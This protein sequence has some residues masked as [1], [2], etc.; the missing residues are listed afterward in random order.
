MV[1]QYNLCM[2]DRVL[3]CYIAYMKEYKGITP[4]DSPINGGLF[5]RETGNAHE[6][7]N[8]LPGA[9]GYVNGF[10]ETKH[11][12][13]YKAHGTK[14]NQLHIEKIDPEAK[15]ADALDHV[16]VFFCAKPSTGKGDILLVGWYE[17][18]TIYRD[19]RFYT[20]DDGEEMGTNIRTDNGKA[21]LIPEGQRKF[22]IPRATDGKGVG[23]GQSNI[24]YAEGPEGEEF[25]KKTFDYIQAYKEQKAEEQSDKYTEIINDVDQIEGIT[26]T[27]RET[28]A[29]SRIGQDLFRSMLFDRDRVCAVCGIE[30]HKL[31]KASHIKP[32]NKCSGKEDRLDVNNGLLLCAQHDALFDKGLISFDEDGRILITKYLSDSDLQILKIDPTKTIKVPQGM[33]PYLK[34]HNDD[35]RKNSRVAVHSKFGEGIII[36]ETKERF[37]IDFD[38]T[39]REISKTMMKSGLLTISNEIFR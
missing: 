32:W 6:K 29:K 22:I 37:T 26:N 7:Y 8:F 21:F 16:T 5:V 10:V 3:F 13:G 33:K 31:L 14:P 1:H 24:W 34:W 12:D 39:I 11:K 15:N 36:N 38:G 9:N 23:F 20:A 4:K 2:N 35:L 27:E 18:A 19:R 25:K 17:D 30:N 28:L